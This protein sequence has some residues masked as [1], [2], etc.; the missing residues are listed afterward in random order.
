M[1][2]KQKKDCIIFPG[3]SSSAAA[4]V[5]H[6]GDGLEGA[7]GQPGGGEAEH[8]KLFDLCSKT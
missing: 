5:P 1:F 6:R 2:V 3:R 7:G 4:H 8:G